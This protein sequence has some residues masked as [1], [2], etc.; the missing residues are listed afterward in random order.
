[1]QAH[2]QGGSQIECS[3]IFCAFLPPVSM[4]F[5]C[6]AKHGLRTRG[7]GWARAFYVGAEGTPTRKRRSNS[8]PD[9]T[10]YMFKTHIYIHTGDNFQTF[11]PSSL[12]KILFY[13]LIQVPYKYD[14]YILEEMGVCWF[15]KKRF[16]HFYCPRKWILTSLYLIYLWWYK[17]W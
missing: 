11:A 14:T 9:V 10:D 6:N 1:M 3:V 4:C 17:L 16:G 5:K 8:S 12:S 13:I 15:L 2:T 7:F